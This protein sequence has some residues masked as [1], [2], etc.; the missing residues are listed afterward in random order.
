MVVMTG[1]DVNDALTIK[2][3]DL[4]I[5]TGSTAPAIKAVTQVVL[6]DSRFLYLSDVVTRGR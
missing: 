6:M 4:G 2:E 1:D 3:A 5:A